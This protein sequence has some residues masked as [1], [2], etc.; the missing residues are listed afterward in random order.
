MLPCKTEKVLGRANEYESDEHHCLYDQ[1]LHHLKENYGAGLLLT[2]VENGIKRFLFE[3]G[4][5]RIKFQS[6]EAFIQF[7]R[8]LE[9]AFPEWFTSSPTRGRV[10]IIG[11][12]AILGLWSSY[13]PPTVFIKY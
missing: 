11:S 1:Y 2:K 12:P 9:K 5:G 13:G 7:I 10:M 4:Q 3:S 6:W 8:L